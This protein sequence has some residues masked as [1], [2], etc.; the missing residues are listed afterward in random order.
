MNDQVGQNDF[1]IS[2]EDQIM[3]EDYLD[4]NST[5]DRSRYPIERN[6]TERQGERNNPLKKYC[7]GHKT[8]TFHG[9]VVVLAN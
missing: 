1:Y 6:M 2:D 5:R 7:Y 9:D 3:Q 8:Q 4:Y